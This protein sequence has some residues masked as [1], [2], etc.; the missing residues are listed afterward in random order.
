MCIGSSSTLTLYHVLC[1]TG[2]SKGWLGYSALLAAVTGS[3]LAVENVMFDTTDDLV[4]TVLRDSMTSYKTLESKAGN[5][6]YNCV[7]CDKTINSVTKF[8]HDIAGPRSDWQ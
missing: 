8:I 3:P 6:R 2:Q 4:Q 1:I 7:V 5:L